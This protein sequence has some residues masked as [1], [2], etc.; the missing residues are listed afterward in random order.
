[1]TLC[2]IP[3]GKALMNLYERPVATSNYRANHKHISSH[4]INI[5]DEKTHT[6]P[7]RTEYMHLRGTNPMVE[8]GKEWKRQAG[9]GHTWAPVL[10][11]AS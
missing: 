11:A 9:M 7:R 3:A 1:M 2:V 5:K 8:A 10:T 6:C 4:Y